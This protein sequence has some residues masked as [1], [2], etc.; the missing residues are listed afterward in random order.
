[1]LISCDM[2]RSDR[3]CLLHRSL[4]SSPNS[5]L[6]FDSALAILHL[7][8]MTK[9]A[10]ASEVSSPQL[11]MVTLEV[12]SSHQLRLL[13]RSFLSRRV[14]TMDMLPMREELRRR[15]FSSGGCLKQWHLLGSFLT[16][17]SSREAGSFNHHRFHRSALLNLG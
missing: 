15:T 1:M 2:I 3:R 12:S 7:F 10:K 13:P 9:M 11:A 5:D 6:Q 4:L 8:L 17:I 14:A 16:W